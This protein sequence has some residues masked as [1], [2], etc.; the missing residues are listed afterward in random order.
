MP[1]PALIARAIRHNMRLWLAER[2]Q[3]W[4]ERYRGTARSR[5]GSR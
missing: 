2:R 3:L 5:S 1:S 4:R